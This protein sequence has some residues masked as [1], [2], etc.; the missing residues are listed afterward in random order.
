[1][2]HFLDGENIEKGLKK[3]H[4]WLKPS[5]KLFFIVVSPYNVAIKEGCLSVYKQR[6]KEGNKWPGVIENQW[7]I[8]PAHKEYVEPYLH[9]FDIPQLEK[10]LPQCGFEI[11]KIK[12]FDFPN[13][14]NSEDKGHVGFV[15]TKI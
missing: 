14:I 10:L 6:V 7:E 8:N 13:E 3:I 1:M 5:G 2:F 9:V 4:S 12:L 15:A 11:K